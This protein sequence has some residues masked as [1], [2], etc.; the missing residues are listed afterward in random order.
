MQKTLAE[1]DLVPLQCHQFSN[2]ETMTVG[3]QN[4]E[5]ISLSEPTLVSRLNHTRNL[6]GAEM[7]TTANRRIR[8]S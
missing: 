1:V 8:P 2:P 3:E 6:R 4:Q 5:R 7:F